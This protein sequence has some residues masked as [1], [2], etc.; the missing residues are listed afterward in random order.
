VAFEILSAQLIDV[1][2][3]AGETAR[4]EIAVLHNV[5]V[6]DGKRLHGFSSY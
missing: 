6:H 4:L 5:V 1:G 2:A 3:F